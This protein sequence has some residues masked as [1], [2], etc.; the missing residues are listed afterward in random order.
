MAAV[1][2][3]ALLVFG[4]LIVGDRLGKGGFGN[5]T[6]DGLAG[7]VVLLGGADSTTTT[8]SL[9]DLDVRFLGWEED[10]GILLSYDDDSR[11]TKTDTRGDLDR[12]AHVVAR[13]VEGT[14][15][16]VALFGHSQAALILDRM[17]VSDLALP[18]SAVV[19]SPPP[20]TTPDLEVPAPN[21]IAEGKPGGDLARGFAWLLE[22]LGFT[23]YDVDTDASPTNL[24]DVIPGGDG[25][26]RRMSVWALADS[27][28][29]DSD[30]R[31]SDETNLV[32]VTDHVGA[33]SDG[34]ALERSADFFAGE[35]AGDDEGSWR[36]ALATTLRYAFAPWRP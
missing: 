20:H 25:G 14:A 24:A 29:L 15:P 32:A 16:P 11:Y 34:Y 8:G 17:I 35:D 1:V 13:Q 21:E 31:R 9:S 33:V 36:G 30:W 19:I 26:V 22:R 18:E 23:P 5:R 27:V 2:G 12:V 10:D 6:V 28:W 3:T 4:V 7:S